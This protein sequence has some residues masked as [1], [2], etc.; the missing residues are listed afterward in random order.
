MKLAVQLEARQML[1]PSRQAADVDAKRVF[2]NAPLVEWRR[3]LAS[4][5]GNRRAPI[6]KPRPTKMRSF[7]MLL[8]RRDAS[9]ASNY[10][11]QKRKTG[12][13]RSRICEREP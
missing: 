1:K 4:L 2:E 3:K 9:C 12:Y 8:N 11:T 6:L 10:W 5:C 13:E 7:R